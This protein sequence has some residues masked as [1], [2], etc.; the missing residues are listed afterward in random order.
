MP[1]HARQTRLAGGHGFVLLEA[2]VALLVIAFGL[3]GLAAMQAVAI[4][5]TSVAKSRSLAAIQAES[6]AATM[7]ANPAY[8]A[9]LSTSTSIS[10]VA[11]SVS[12]SNAPTSAGQC[13]TASCTAVQM[14]G[15]DMQN[16]GVA[17]LGVAPSAQ[18]A[19]N[20]T[21]LTVASPVSCTIL[22][23]WVEKTAALN[24]AVTASAVSSTVS[25][26]MVVQP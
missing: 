1:R 14:A 16:W 5:N 13:G 24:A 2:L 22:V 19:V 20:C 6:L 9:A 21:G 26:Q 7:H 10:V 23:S 17:L 25:Y 11:S 8:W 15:Y 12:G 18:G 4:N 3:L